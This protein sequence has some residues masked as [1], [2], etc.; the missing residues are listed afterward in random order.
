M[1]NENLEKDKY[2]VIE[3]FV[4]EELLKIAETYYQL[5]FFVNKDFHTSVGKYTH[6]IGGSPDVVQPC[7]IKD[8]A[9]GFT[10]SICWTFTEKMRE[11]TGVKELRPSYSYVRFYEKGQWLETHSDRPSC[12]YSITLPLTAYDDTPWEIFLEGNS[13]DLK[14]GDMLAYKGCEA[15]HWREPFKGEWQ[16]QAHLHYVDASD[17]AYK[18]YVNDKRPVFG[19]RTHDL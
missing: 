5:K 11:I 19:L 3:N 17:P 6:Q 9:D 15:T 12:Q 1:K 7:S 13:I 8:Y 4:S 16:V 18:D 14:L 2:I 10:E